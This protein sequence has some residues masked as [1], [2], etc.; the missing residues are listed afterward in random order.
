[1]RRLKRNIAPFMALVF[2]VMIATITPALA[3]FSDH[4]DATGKVAVQIG[5]T[6]EME[7]EVEGLV[8]TIHI[9]NSGPESC[10][11]RA[12]AYSGDNLEL[13]YEGE[14]WT[15]GSSDDWYYYSPVL[16]AEQETAP[17]QVT[18]S[19]VPQDA[20]EGDSFNVV[21][22]YESVKVLYADNGDPLPADWSMEGIVKEGSG[23]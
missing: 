7:E 20:V 9:T 10:Y 13:A 17:L 1:M 14:G 12:K 19:S 11:V 3:Y 18:I 8:K 15:K 21:V 5:F 23:D 6:T 16:N 22:V 2:I 4:V